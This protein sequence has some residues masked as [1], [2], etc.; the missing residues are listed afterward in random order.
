LDASQ[1]KR[2]SVGVR[3]A[4]LVAV[5]VPFGALLLAIVSFWGGG[6]SWTDF[7]LLAGVYVS[8]VLG[9]T[10]GSH[11]LFTHRAF[12]NHSFVEFI[13]GVLGSMAVQGRLFNWVALNPR[14]HQHSDE[15]NDPYSPHQCE[16][17]WGVVRRLWH[18]HIGSLFRPKPADLRRR[19]KDLRQKRHLRIRNRL[20]FLWV[21]AGM[22]IPAA[23]GGLLAQSWAGAPS[24]FV[25][26]A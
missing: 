16:G 6:F 26:V 1:Q 15:I 20:F 22:L 9:I 2:I 3:L 19:V 13:R 5:I 17:A 10:V 8:T 24:G 11:R 18:G 12:E 25:W 23:I 7:A 4:N 14:H 21:A